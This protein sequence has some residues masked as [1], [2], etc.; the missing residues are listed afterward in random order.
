MG[1]ELAPCCGYPPSPLTSE[2]VS[3]AALASRRQ[4]LHTSAAAHMPSTPGPSAF[5]STCGRGVRCTAF[6]R[7]AAAPLLLK[8]ATTRTCSTRMTRLRIA[9]QRVGGEPHKRAQK[10]GGPHLLQQ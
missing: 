8:A 9:G 5:R 1:H 2:A 4:R 7:A 10:Q 6:N 3:A